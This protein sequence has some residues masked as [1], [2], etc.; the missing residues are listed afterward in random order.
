MKCVPSYFAA[1]VM[2]YDANLVSKDL[3]GI[4]DWYCRLVFELLVKYHAVSSLFPSLSI[5]G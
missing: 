1:L 5:A 4:A 3:Q 2:M